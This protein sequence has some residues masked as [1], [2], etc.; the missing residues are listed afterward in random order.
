[1]TRRDLVVY[2]LNKPSRCYGCDLKLPADEIVKL[3]KGNDEREV[4]C[5]A[6][7]GLTDFELIKPGNAQ[8]TRKASKLSSV[9]YVV[10]KWSE[11]W[12]CYERAG[13]LVEKEALQKAMEK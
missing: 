4:L 5:V 11:L 9:R 10:M 2:A 6:C 7:A 3:E 1:M 12:K 13:V 8:L